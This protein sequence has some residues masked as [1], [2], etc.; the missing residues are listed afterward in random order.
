MLVTLSST[1]PSV[2]DLGEI[3]DVYVHLF[4]TYF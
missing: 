1:P 2:F 4:A 3:E